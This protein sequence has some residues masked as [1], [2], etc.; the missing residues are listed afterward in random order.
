[1][2]RRRAGK[3]KGERATTRDQSPEERGKE[4]KTKVGGGGGERKRLKSFGSASPSFP[5]SPYKSGW[6]GKGKTFFSVR[7][8]GWIHGW[9]HLKAI[10]CLEM[11]GRN[12]KVLAE[13]HEKSAKIFKQS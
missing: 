11:K 2:D 4:E 1:M 8:R 3:E 5:L 9:D 6:D 12:W 7:L 13:S 10:D